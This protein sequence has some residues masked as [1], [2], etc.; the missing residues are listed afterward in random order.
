LEAVFVF[1]W[2]LVSREVGWPGYIDI[3]VFLTILLVALLYLARCGALAWNEFG[4]PQWPVPQKRV[5][6]TILN[7][8]GT[9]GVV[10]SKH[11][12]AVVLLNGGMRAVASGCVGRVIMRIAGGTGR[13]ESS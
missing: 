6:S 1:A 13:H 10:P 2:S 5:C 9:D 8:T 11:A 4:G 12:K 3:L 7:M